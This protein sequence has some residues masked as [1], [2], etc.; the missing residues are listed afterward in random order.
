[1][2]RYEV[3]NAI[4]TYLSNGITANS[5]PYLNKVYPYPPKVTPQTDMLPLTIAG[6][7]S[8]AVCYIHLISQDEKRIAVGGLHNGRKWREYN[9]GIVVY[10]Y[11]VNTQS[12]VIGQ[13]NDTLLDALVSYILADRNAG[14]A[15]VIF[16]WGEGTDTGGDDIHVSAGMP[17]VFNQ[18]GA[19][20]F[21][22]IELMAVEIIDS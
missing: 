21:S 11:G 5:I 7:D 14:N 10:Q 1:M 16:Q 19:Y 8:G 9:V 6:Q 22:T 17:V 18:Q 4:A 12:E 15:S 2:G 3:R 13:E 20:V